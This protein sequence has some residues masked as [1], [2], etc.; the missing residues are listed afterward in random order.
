MSTIVS[1]LKETEE[2]VPT[3]IVN[4]LSRIFR[5]TN[6]RKD[7]GRLIRLHWLVRWTSG[8]GRVT[9]WNRAT[10]SRPWRPPPGLPRFAP[11]PRSRYPIPADVRLYPR[12][13]YNHFSGRLRRPISMATY[14][15][16]FAREQALGN[17]DVEIDGLAT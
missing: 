14:H 11:Q 3:G 7:F 17:D 10:P 4:S 6:K 8:V 1:I 13:A 15:G 9:G 16:I 5:R 12:R 2:I